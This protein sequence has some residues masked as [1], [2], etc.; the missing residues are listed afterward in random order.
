M[1]V[2]QEKLPAS[3]IG[4][5]IE[6]PAET[7]KQVYENIVQ[8]LARSINL[9]G[10]RKGKV[11]RH[12]LLQR[13]G[14]QRVKAE[15]L[16]KLVQDSL[17]QALKTEAIEAIGNYQL[18]SSFDELVNQYEPGQPLVFSASVD[19][20]PDVE[21]GE[22]KGLEATAEEVPYN[23]AEVDELLDRQREKLSTLVPVED[24]PAQMGDVAIADYAGRLAD[25]EDDA[26][27][28]EG[29]EATDFQMELSEGRFVAGLIEGVVGMKPGETKEIAVTFPEDYPREDL[30][31]Q[32]V[33][34]T[35]TLKE[36]KEKELPE[37]DDDFAEE[38]SEFE[39]LAELRESLESQFQEKAERETQDNV[40]EALVEE[41]LKVVTVDPPATMLD[42]E[43]DT[44][45][46]Q[47]AMQLQQYG[48]DVKGIFTQENIQAMKERSRPEAL[49]NIKRT[50]ALKEIAKRENLNPAEDEI[51]AKMQEI[52][53]EL[54]DETLDP[55][56]LR[57]FVVEDLTKEKTLAWLKE[58]SQ[59]TLVPPGTLKKDEADAETE[60]E[61]E[62]SEEVQSSST[63]EE[64]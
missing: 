55:N 32:A 13:L 20:E 7:S 33:I 56:R 8:R 17:E 10:F 50:L 51:T 3:Q 16:E 37:L 54:A 4:L 11:P 43:L 64:Q 23:P 61:A 28:I 42:R 58:Q 39:T 14:P 31:E 27:P 53:E 63:S 24:R 18:I 19:V 15:A 47:T 35:L 57:T 52:T 41:L 30:A 44:M 1:K 22:Y 25:A 29:T 36:L 9:P 49:Q 38:V 12:V 45:L 6:I 26:E 46:T 60:S 21:L 59:I 5:A 62:S 40:E 34:F 2:T 48:M